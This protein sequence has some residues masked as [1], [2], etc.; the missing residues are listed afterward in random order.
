MALAAGQV[1]S[2]AG[3]AIISSFSLQSTLFITGFWRVMSCLLSMMYVVNRLCVR[4]AHK[5]N[6]SMRQS[7][8]S[9]QP[10]I[11][12]SIS[13]IRNWQDRLSNR[14]NVPYNF[15]CIVVMTR[16]NLTTS[17]K[18]PWPRK[19]TYIFNPCF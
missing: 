11:L 19:L 13:Y 15:I 6:R 8:R 7:A 5:G 10:A 2:P 16:R 4:R 17:V 1:A 9:A 18:G 14:R 3:S 12:Y